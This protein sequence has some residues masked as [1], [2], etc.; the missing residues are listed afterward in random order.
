MIEEVTWISK[1]LQA[2]LSD[3]PIS[4]FKTTLKISDSFLNKRRK[5]NFCKLRI[6]QIPDRR[7][8]YDSSYSFDKKR[9]L[10]DQPKVINSILAIPSSSSNFENKH[11]LIILT[12]VNSVRKFWRPCDLFRSSRG[13][14]WWST[15]ETFC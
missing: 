15:D 11:N 3:F 14:K 10:V 1:M 13:R 8:V 6:V 9:A 4:D 5:N 7:I 12:R 2:A